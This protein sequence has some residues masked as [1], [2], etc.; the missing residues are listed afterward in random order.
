MN[1][2]PTRGGKREG[3]G[4]KAKEP[5]EKLVTVSVCVSPVAAQKLADAA[6]A[7]GT[8][9]SQVADAAFRRIRT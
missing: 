4:R 6:E 8:S 7:K 2:K 1:P 3:S 5:G 9:K